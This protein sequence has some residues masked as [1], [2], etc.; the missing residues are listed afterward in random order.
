MHL[1]RLSS[2]N[3]AVAVLSWAAAMLTEYACLQV[4]DN[5]L[6]AVASLDALKAVDVG[7]SSTCTRACLMSLAHLTNLQCLSVTGRSAH[8]FGSLSAKDIKKLAAMPKLAVLEVSLTAMTEPL[9]SHAVSLPGCLR[10]AEHGMAAP[11]HAC[12]AMHATARWH[13]VPRKRSQVGHLS[14]ITE[15][16]I[17]CSMACVQMPGF[18]AVQTCQPPACAFACDFRC[19]CIRL[20]M[21]SKTEHL[22]L[23]C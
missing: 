13:H 7:F 16:R 4:T 23:R 1:V 3:W 15:G 17:L 19:I 9:G 14:V 6:R 18:I 21:A 20:S 8:D 2:L 10:S 11:K 22:A 12:I 5:M